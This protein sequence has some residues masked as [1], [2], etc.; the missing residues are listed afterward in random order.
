MRID[1]KILTPPLERSAS[2]PGA[3]AARPGAHETEAAVVT[4][5]AA[6]AAVQA[7]KLNELVNARLEQIRLL[8]DRGEYPIDLDRLAARIADDELA[9]RIADDKRAARM[10]DDASP[11]ESGNP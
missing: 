6:G 4:L 3:T 8:L 1:P 5:S 7:G 2:E 9:A 11:R 10:G